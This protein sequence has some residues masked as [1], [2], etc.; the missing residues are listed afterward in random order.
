[1]LLNVLTGCLEIW[2]FD[3]IRFI[4]YGG[5]LCGYAFNMYYL[6][7]ESE[8]FRNYNEIDGDM[9]ENFYFRAGMEHMLK[10]ARD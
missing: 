9:R 2:F 8:H 3:G 10:N 5:I 7:R 6:K 4:V 1:M